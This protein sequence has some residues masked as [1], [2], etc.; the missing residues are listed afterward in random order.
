MSD[1]WKW[2]AE[3]AGQS[4][5]IGGDLGFTLTKGGVYKTAKKTIDLRQYN[6]PSH[7][8]DPDYL[9]LGNWVSNRSEPPQPVDLAPGEQYSYVSLWCMMACPMFF[10]GDLA[11][12]DAFTYGLLCNT[13]MIAVN[14]DRLG[15]CAEPVVMDSNQWVLKKPLSDGSV[16]VGLFNLE[17]DTAR[18]ITVTWAQLGLPGP[19]KARDLWRQRDVDFPADGMK[20]K[21][22]PLGCAVL[23]ISSR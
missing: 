12:V 4:W 1:V 5:R 6:G 20:V 22:G 7:W 11:T 13:E 8:N 14:Q 3:V 21:L 23:R 18:E 16:V 19:S 15:I 2:G 10:S 9:I 17:K